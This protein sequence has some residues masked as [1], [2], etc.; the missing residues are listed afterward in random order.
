MHPMG[1]IHFARNFG[2]LDY[3][4]QLGPEDK[5]LILADFARVAGMRLLVSFEFA[6]NAIFFVAAFH[7]TPAGGHP[8]KYKN[9]H[10]SERKSEC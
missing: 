5:P 1:F 2:F 4:F 7:R 10:E 6:L 9:L 3:R 8:S